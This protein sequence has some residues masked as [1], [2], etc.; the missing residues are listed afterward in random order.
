MIMFFSL[1]ASALASVYDTVRYNGCLI[2]KP[3]SNS[4]LL[5]KKH[6]IDKWID[7]NNYT[8]S[9]KYE[10]IITG[11]SYEYAS[12]KVYYG[13]SLIK[14]LDALY[15]IDRATS[16][17]I[18][19]DTETVKYTSNY[20][21]PFSKGMKKR[22]ITEEV[23]LRDLIYY[24]VKYSDNTAHLMLIDYIG[25]NN[26]KEYGIS[27]GGTILLST[28]DKFGNQTVED[29]NKYLLR[30]YEIIKRDDE[31]GKFL[32]D[33]MDNDERNSFNN[34][35]LKIHHKYGAYG[36][37]YHDVG[38]NLM[39]NHPYAISIFT[40]YEGRQ[41]KDVIQK[42]HSKIIELHTSFWCRRKYQCYK[43]I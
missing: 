11:F 38:L 6:E 31:Y 28:T 9:V 7:E 14:I 26:L 23:S 21:R 29:M 1:K 39:D 24:A 18:N 42:V 30:A 25:F 32:K 20:I 2:D 5:D 33:I 43:K 13:A 41:Y 40:L 19:L 4:D 22:M 37:N 27:L 16:D 12:D 17:K 15:L 3:I 34:G 36:N 8:I 35:N 10:D